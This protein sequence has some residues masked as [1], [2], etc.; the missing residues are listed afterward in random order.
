MARP[1]RRSYPLKAVLYREGLSDYLECGHT[2]PTPQD[3]I[4]H[5]YPE[6]RRCHKCHKEKPM[7]FTP[8]PIKKG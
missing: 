8:P 5:Y 6:R 3:I 1:D 2:L 7:D 4:G